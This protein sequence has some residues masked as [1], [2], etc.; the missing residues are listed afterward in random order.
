MATHYHTFAVTP[1]WNRSLVMT[2]AVGAHFFHRWKGYWGTRAAFRQAYD[3]GE[4]LPGPHPRPIAPLMPQMTMA[5]VAKVAPVPSTAAAV[6]QPAYAQSGLPAGGYVKPVAA[7]AVGTRT[8]DS[9][10]LD[11]WKDSGKPLR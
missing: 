4:P 5:A 3:G 9:Q 1:S 10:I 7:L 6:I 11:R 8:D 2:A